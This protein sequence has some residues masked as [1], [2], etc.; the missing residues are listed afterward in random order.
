MIHF[1]LSYGSTGVVTQVYSTGIVIQYYGNTGIVTHGRTGI[2][3]QVVLVLL[4]MAVLVYCYT[5]W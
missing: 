4:H 2:V 5:I 1:L 3:I